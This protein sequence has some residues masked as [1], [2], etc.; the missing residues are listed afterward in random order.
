VAVPQ[1]AGEGPYQDLIA[2][3]CGTLTPENELKWGH[4]SAREG[5]YDFSGADQ[6]E[7]FARTNDMAMRGHALLWHSSVP[8]WLARTGDR[9]ALSTSIERHIR[10]VVGCYKGRIGTWD[11]VNEP[12]NLEDGQSDGLRASTFLAGLGPNY[13]PR[14]L[15][16][17]H[18]CDPDAQLCINEYN[19]EY[20]GSYFEGR[21]SSLLRLVSRMKG[22]GVPL[23]VVGVQAHLA[24]NAYGF[25]ERRFRDFLR[26]LAATGVLIEITELDV[27]DAEL[28]GGPDERDRLVAEEYER[29]LSVALDERAVRAVTTWGLSDA[30]SW[31]NTP[32]APKEKR[33]KDGQPNRPLPF[34]GELRRKAAWEALAKALDAAPDRSA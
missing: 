5:V 24:V 8:D 7:S 12:I 9:D 15:R 30:Y 1:A 32:A 20:E 22:E 17:A 19:L 31:L 34:D 25:S 13:L 14:A 2:L 11:V 29:F 18:E 4:L 16:T 23:N 6:L 3:E 28:S 21:R 26:D 10:T 27:S 33:R